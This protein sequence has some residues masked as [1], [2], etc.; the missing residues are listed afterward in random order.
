MRLLLDNQYRTDAL[1]D[2]TSSPDEN[3]VEKL[4]AAGATEVVPETLEASL[5]IAAQALL[6]LDVPISRIVRVMQG[7]R[8]ERYRLKALPLA[9]R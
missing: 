6:L 5:M 3:H 7:Q 1:A 8:S 9:G 2:H 4:Q